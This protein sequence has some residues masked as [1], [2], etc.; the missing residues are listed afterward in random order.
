MKKKVLTIVFVLLLYALQVCMAYAAEDMPRL[1]DAAG[2]LSEGEKTALLNE[3]DEISERQRVDTIVITLESLE[4]ASGAEY[5]DDFYDYYEYGFGEEKDGILLLISME[6]RDWYISTKGYGITAV[7]DAGLDYISE[8][9]ID[10]LSEGRYAEAFMVFAELC[11]DFITQ[12]ETGKPYDIG[13]LPKEPFG[14]VLNLAITFGIGFIFSLIIMGR[15]RNRLKT[16]GRQPG[17]ENYVKKNSMNLTK[18]RDLFLYRHVD[19]REKAD[20]H[21]ANDS[22]GSETHTSSSGET[23]GGG[24]GKF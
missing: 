7:T 17:A 24:G 22:G 10:D 9:M 1:I 20:D 12:A 14:F 6:E 2:L 23:H 5:A 21:G 8:S 15:M 13:N 19:R 3:L 11:D 16:V 18:E 4:G